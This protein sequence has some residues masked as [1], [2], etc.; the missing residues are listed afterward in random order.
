[1]KGCLSLSI[2]EESNSSAYNYPKGSQPPENRDVASA[3]KA[4]TLALTL[5][6]RLA[7]NVYMSKIKSNP[8]CPGPA[9]GMVDLG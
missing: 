4:T 7:L 6:R 1:M 9:Q 8:C 5:S 3:V 2:C